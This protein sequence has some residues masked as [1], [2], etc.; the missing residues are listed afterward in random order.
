M[1][2]T[3]GT[4]LVRPSSVSPGYASA[5]SYPT[6]TMADVLRAAGR[7]DWPGYVGAPRLAAGAF[8]AKALLDANERPAKLAQEILDGKDAATIP[9]RRVTNSDSEQ[10]K[11]DAAAEAN[12][13]KLEAQ[14]NDWLEKR[15]Q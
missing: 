5:P 8:G 1:R 6:P 7:P 3:S 2:E 13:G 12:D 14:Q 4:L 9:R 11:V 10:T 15:K